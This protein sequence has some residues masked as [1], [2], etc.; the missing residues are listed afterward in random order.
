M[1]ELILNRLLRHFRLDNEFYTELHRQQI[2]YVYDRL[3][4]QVGSDFKT[5][6]GALEALEAQL[7]TR[8]INNIYQ[9]LKFAH[10]TGS[11]HYDYDTLKP[12]INLHG[13]DQGWRL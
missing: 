10:M 5:V 1:D 7:H 2:E 8:R 6:L 11:G 3:A 13:Y 12:P 4:E 9:H